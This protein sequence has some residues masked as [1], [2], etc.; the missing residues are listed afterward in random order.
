MTSDFFIV[1]S[2]PD[3]FSVMAIESLSTV[4]PRWHAWSE[5]AKLNPILRGAA[6]PY[7]DKI[8]KFLGTVIQK[9]RPR[10][11]APT[12]GFQSW[13]D[14]IND[15]VARQ[16]APT[17]NPLK[18][19]LPPMVYAKVAGLLPGYCLAQIADFNTLI[20]K[21]QEHKTPVFALT[22]AQLGHVGVVLG[23][24][25]G[26]REEFKDVFSSLASQVEILTTNEIS[27]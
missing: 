27:A 3:Y 2:S 26:K 11:G 21:S 6:Y 4:I 14:S 9:Y 15:R 16:L 1:P 5:R 24:D 8:P 23:I 13:I 18:M 17:L 10:K 12:E 25:Q 20:A 19:L 22:D 7:P